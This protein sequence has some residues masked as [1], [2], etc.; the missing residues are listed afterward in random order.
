MRK[1]HA[2]YI[3]CL[4]VGN[5]RQIF[6]FTP[7]PPIPGQPWKITH[8]HDMFVQEISYRESTLMTFNLEG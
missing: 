3:I 7:P 5:T 2:K 8:L 4:T 1:D 6:I